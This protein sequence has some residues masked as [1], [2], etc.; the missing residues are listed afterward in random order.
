MTALPADAAKHK[1]MVQSCYAGDIPDVDAFWKVWCFLSLLSIPIIIATFVVQMISSRKIPQL[2]H[3]SFVFYPIERSFVNLT[4]AQRRLQSVNPAEV[5]YA[6]WRWRT[7][8]WKRPRN[9]APLAA[10]APAPVAACP[11]LHR[12]RRAALAAAATR[13]LSMATCPYL[14]W[15]VPYWN[16]LIFINFKLP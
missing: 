6:C 1:F 7:S 15:M 9:K 11:L 3:N 4:H 5:H 16:W 14:W 13:W 8:Q 10:A 12:P 2:L